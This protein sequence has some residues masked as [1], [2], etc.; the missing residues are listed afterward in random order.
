M[1]TSY[2]FIFQFQYGFWSSIPAVIKLSVI[3]AYC[4]GI[5][6][7][8]TLNKTCSLLAATETATVTAPVSLVSEIPPKLF[9]LWWGYGRRAIFKIL[10]NL[11]WQRYWLFPI[12]LSRLTADLLWEVYNSTLRLIS[13][14]ML[15]NAHFIEIHACTQKRPIMWFQ[16][17]KRYWTRKRKLEDYWTL[18]STE[19]VI[20]NTFLLVQYSFFL[21]FFK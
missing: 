11:N 16:N 6:Y 2:L 14:K 15:A 21:S 7:F 17:M 5:I 13:F 3:I 18:S 8:P 20:F 10:Y 1:H 9:G 12:T 19:I 4:R